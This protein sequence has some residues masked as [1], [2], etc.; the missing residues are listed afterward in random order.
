M[1]RRFHA[2]GVAIDREAAN[3]LANT[4][5]RESVFYDDIEGEA[6]RVGQIL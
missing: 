1:A 2:S 6:P 5:I 3:L 4:Q